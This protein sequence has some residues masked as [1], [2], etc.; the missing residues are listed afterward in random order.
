[1]IWVAM[2]V[3]LFRATSSPSCANFAL[4]AIAEQWEAEFGSEAAECI[5]KSFYVDDCLKSSE[6]IDKAIQILKSTT[7]LC[8]S[9]G[10]YLTKV[11]SNS[12]EVL[13][14]VSEHDKKPCYSNERALGIEWNTKSDMF[15]F[16]LTLKCY[17]KTKR[18]ILSALS[19][20]YDPIVL[21]PCFILKV[22]GSFNL[23]ILLIFYR[24]RLFHH[25]R[26]HAGTAGNLKWTTLKKRYRG[27][28]HPLS[29][30]LQKHRCITFPMQAM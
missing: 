9:G 2:N 11:T 25:K 21:F 6:T 20:L 24:T 10:F 22:N 15:I 5:R 27:V 17:P 8:A 26:I 12:S 1:M 14:K 13:E 7:N 19:S 30:Q 23:F 16:Y 28:S 29:L 18:G 4:R 3:H